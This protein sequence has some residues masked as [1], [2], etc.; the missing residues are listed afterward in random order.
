MA[1]DVK[2]STWIESWSEDGDDVTFPIASVPQLTADEADATG[3]DI[4]KVL[5]ALLEQLWDVWR[6]LDEADK[7]T[8]M[9]LVKNSAVNDVTGVSTNIFTVRFSNEITSQDVM[10][11]PA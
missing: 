8:R 5:F 9:N 2:P 7:P 4:R 10:D 11:E 6:A 1:L 3:G